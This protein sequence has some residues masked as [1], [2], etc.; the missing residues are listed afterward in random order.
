V[1]DGGAGID[2]D[3]LRSALGA[4][5][6]HLADGSYLVVRDLDDE[7]YRYVVRDGA[8]RYQRA[9]VTYEDEEG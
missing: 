7:Q 8:V 2:E 3:D 6:P 5:A 4:L 9:A 1:T